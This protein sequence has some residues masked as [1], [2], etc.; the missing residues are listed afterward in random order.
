MAQY[1]RYC[2]YCINGDCYYCTSKDK[3]LNRVDVAVKCKDFE[4][5]VLGDVETGKKYKPRIKTEC[6]ENV[7][8]DQMTFIGC[9]FCNGS[10]FTAVRK[11]EKIL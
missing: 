9:D 4:L 1:C 7:C 5:S 11:G 10:S 3:V 6:R 2:A 8:D